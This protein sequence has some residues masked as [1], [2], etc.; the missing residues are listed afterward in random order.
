MLPLRRLRFESVGHRDARLAPLWLDFTAGGAPA[1]SVLWLRNGG[2]KS[3][4][5]NLFFALVRPD[6]REFLGSEAEGRDRR[7]EDYVAAADTAHVAAEWD[8]SGRGSLPGMEGHVVTG[9]VLEWRDRARSADSSRLRRAWYAFL[10]RP[11]GLALETLPVVADG[12]VVG[13]ARFLDLLREE[14]RADPALELTISDTQG[15]WQRR[16]ADLGL[17]PEVFRYQLKMN[18]REGT[19]HDLFR[20]RDAGEFVDF[21]LELVSD[22]TEAGQ[23]A[24]N[25]AAYAEELARRPALELERRFVG[26]ALERLAPLAAA[27]GE[28]AGTLAAL[29]EAWRAAD[30]RRRGL[31]AAGRAARTLADDRADEARRHREEHREHERRRTLLNQ[32]AAEAG[33]VAADLRAA[34][35]RARLDAAARALE[36]ATA[37]VAAWEAAELLAR[38]RELAAEV[39]ALERE[40]ER[41]EREA[42]PVR[43]ERDA[44]AR[45]LVA[46]LEALRRAA[47]DAA[48]QA[49][50]DAAHA[51]GEIAAASGRRLEALREA[52][53]AD[54]SLAEIARRRE[55]AE[56]ERRALEAGGLLLPGEAPDDALERTE[57]QDARLATAV[58]EAEERL[59]RISG[60][61]RDAASALVEA[62]RELASRDAERDALAER[63]EGLRERIERLGTDSR[64]TEL[65]EADRVDPWAAG[66]ALLERLAR[67]VD[68]ADADLVAL[69]IGGLEDRR[70]LAALAD[71][72]LL[73]PS[74]DVE[75]VLDALGVGG[76][77]ASSGWRHLAESVP[78][79]E[80][81]DALRRRPDLAAGVVVTVV[82]ELPAARAVLDAA[83]LVL[84]SPVAVGDAAGFGSSAA[85]DG[86]VLAPAPALF[87]PA[88]GAPEMTARAVAVETLDARR[89]ELRRGREGDAALAGELRRF[90]AEF[91]EGIAERWERDL[92]RQDAA[93]AA[94]RER[95]QAAEEAEDA[96]DRERDATELRLGEDREARRALAGARPRIEGCGRRAAEAAAQA[97]EEGRLRARRT[98]CG[99]AGEAA[100]A[101]EE[102]WRRLRADSER[103]RAEHAALGERLAG[104]RAGLEVEG[105][106]REDAA[107]E[108]STEDLR[109]RYAALDARWR[110]LVGD[111]VL[112]D[113]RDR[114][115]AGLRE[116]AAALSEAPAP[117]LEAAGRILEEPAQADAGARAAGRRRAE[118][119]REAAIGRRA[120]AEA[121]VGQAERRVADLAPQEGRRAE[122]PPDLRPETAAAAERLAERLDAEGLLASQ[123]ATASLKAAEEAERE[124]RD[125]AMAA[126]RFGD[127]ADKLASALAHHPELA[128]EEAGSSP[129]WPFDGDTEAARQAESEA[130][131]ALSAAA[132]ADRLA[133]K[134]VNELA[135]AVR[136]HALGEA[137]SDL[138]GKVRD[139]LVLDSLEVLGVRAPE[140]AAALEIRLAQLD[141]QLASLA[142][143]QDIV[144]KELAGIVETA[145][146]HL[147]RAESSSRLPE[148][149]EGW[150]NRPFL[151]LSFEA[152][153]RDEELFAR[154]GTVVDRVVSEGSVPEGMPLLLRAVHAAV[155][156][157]GFEV[158]ILKP[159][160][161]LR[162]ERHPVTAMSKFSDGQQLTAAILLYCTLARLRARNRGRAHTGSG[163]L[164]LDNPIGTCSNV[165]LLDLQ[166][167]VAAAMGVQL[168]Y[169]TGVNDLDALATLPNRVRLRNDR[170]DLRTGRFHVVNEDEPATLRA[171]RVWRREPAGSPP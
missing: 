126:E 99:A 110:G 101:E 27:T 26:G 50:R 62:T 123:Q 131:E 87:D 153:E 149:L 88:A 165:A 8:A 14:A 78:A 79:G 144:V 38:R 20:F 3:S 121:A 42:A 83:G 94:L 55:D 65:A 91:P 125:A 35:A 44:A 37:T 117:A 51:D 57:R 115:A 59:V 11:G 70:A 156:R 82:S 139:R 77:A 111:S 46:R 116:V 58:A 18:R 171:A 33:R 118:D 143:H 17:D 7:L 133:A 6:R 43:A 157:K 2:G 155:G 60:E 122:L 107:A 96:L 84:S 92:E 5:L 76:V 109:A 103:R 154:L 102:E 105:D 71:T 159:D 12:R 161:V 114:A 141:Q 151:R 112:A 80:R 132:D 67:L 39:E 13:I 66:P 34:E 85:S 45:R 147:R 113:R 136:A 137:F 64:L 53:R 127:L 36:A 140:H 61:R 142:A 90:L 138:R 24:A 168:V 146:G 169:T 81:E 166:R 40:L 68:A 63:L 98:E 158:S 148:A 19:A 22:P 75:K 145:L 130:R 95:I 15:E 32:Q 164:I 52:D 129:V 97:A 69:E 23:V 25:L 72:G 47:L 89:Y 28:R 54:A 49:D 108:V 150:A 48:A 73:P 41:V 160:A 106:P 56:A 29:A 128:S 170:V 152:P 21:L 9:M 162:P 124:A 104:E 4:I 100:I 167:R 86:F 10:A 119:D 31:E 30:R 163:V 93:R 120:V 74:L 134:R 1:D 135:E 16:L